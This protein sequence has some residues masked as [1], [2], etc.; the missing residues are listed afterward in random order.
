VAKPRDES[1]DSLRI[2]SGVCGAKLGVEV[3]LDSLDERVLDWECEWTARGRGWWE[4][5]RE[6]SAMGSLLSLSS[7]ILRPLQ[8][9]PSI[10][11]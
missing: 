10:M 4:N 8:F 2:S 7:E 5:L 6:G 11:C 1:C 9:L 3:Q